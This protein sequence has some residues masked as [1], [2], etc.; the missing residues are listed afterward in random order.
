MNKNGQKA[1]TPSKLSQWWQKVRQQAQQARTY[2]KDHYKELRNKQKHYDE[3]SSEESEEPQYPKRITMLTV[4]SIMLAELGE[5]EYWRTLWHLLWRPGYV[6]ADFLNGKRRKFLR[7]FQLLIGT[8][9]LLAIALYIVP[10]E[11]KP[12]DSYEERLEKIL[13][14]DVHAQEFSAKTI[15]SLH[16]ITHYA[17]AYVAWLNEHFAVGLLIKS[18]FVIFFTWLLFRKSPRHDCPYILDNADGKKANYNFAEIL[19][20]QIFIITQLQMLNVAWVLVTG[21]SVP[22]INLQPYAYPY[23]IANII[24]FFDFQQ[25]FGRKWY[26]T[27]WRT[28]LALLFVL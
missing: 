24:V 23:I 2:T 21:W 14:E 19:T 26:D 11:I 9:L 28:V 13:L 16:K 6:I 7:P 27:L 25:L 15:D 10:A 22:Y 5:K 20:A 12:V 8:T 1:K 18:I 4:V 17:D 3:E